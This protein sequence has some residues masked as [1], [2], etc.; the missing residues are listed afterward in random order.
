MDL[1]QSI[2]DYLETIYLIKNRKGQ[3][4]LKD[5]VEKL[6][7]APPSVTEAVGNM[8]KKGFVKHEK[9]GSIELTDKGIA[10]AERVYQK[11]RI[12]FEFFS[13]I[14]SVSEENAEIDACEVEH[15]ISKETYEKLV[16]FIEFVNSCDT[17]PNWLKGFHYYLQNG[18]KPEYCNKGGGTMS[19]AGLDT[20]NVGKRARII[21]I[22][23]DKNMKKRLL[24]MGF[25]PG[26]TV[27]VAGVAPLGDPIEIKLRG[28]K[29]SLRKEEAKFIL[30]EEEE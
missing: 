14:L 26:T 17:R 5:I 25:I 7:I 10:E 8:I 18:V 20:V 6:R 4:R 23:A 2:E 9:Y 30:I 21:K 29:I 24:D 11:H 19:K 15:Y 27:E 16:S 22:D 13:N 28:Y 12:L 3:V 1:T